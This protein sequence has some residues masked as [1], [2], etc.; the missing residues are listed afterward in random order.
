MPLFDVTNKDSLVKPKNAENYDVLQEAKRAAGTIRFNK[1]CRIIDEALDELI[2][3]AALGDK[4]VFTKAGFLVGH[5][6]CVPHV[7]VNHV[8]FTAEMAY[9]TNLLKSGRAL[10]QA[11]ELQLKFVGGLVRWR[12]SLQDDIWLVYREPSGTYNKYTGNEITI[13]KYWIDNDYVFPVEKKEPKFDY[14]H[15]HAHRKDFTNNPF[16][17]LRGKL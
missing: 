17:G 15:E 3:D 6:S 16:T 13:S 11:N 1:D 2:L 7:D 5:K 9:P 12:I 4:L 14:E 8:W 10:D